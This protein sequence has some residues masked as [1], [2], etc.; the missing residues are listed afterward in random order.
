MDE[1]DIHGDKRKLVRYLERLNDPNI[2][3]ENQ[4][5]IRKFY[6]SC[7]LQGMSKGRIVR[8]LGILLITAKAMNKD[9]QKATRDDIKAFI[10]HIQ[11]KDYSPFTKHQYKVIIR[12]FY[13]WLKGN[14]EEYPQEVKWLKCRVKRSEHKLPGEGE[15]L[16]EQDVDKL[17]KTAE[18]SRDK[19]LISTL[20]ESG[21]RIGEI[22][23]LTIGKVVF[24]DYGTVISVKGKTG[25]RKIRLVSST[26]YL[27]N[28]IQDHPFK[29]NKDAQLW[30]TIGQRNY[31]KAMRYCTIRNRLYKLVKKSGIQ[32]RCNPH[33]FRHSRATYL[34]NHLTEFQMNQYFGW[35][36][37]SDM[38]ST[39]VHLS[40]REVDGAILELNG[41]KTE[42]SKQKSAL[43][44]IKCP[45]CDTFNNHDSKFCSK[46]GGVTDL[47]IAMELEDQRTKEK[48]IRKGSDDMMN[49]LMN[50]PEVQKFLMDKL[51]EM[52]VSN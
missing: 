24:D 46:C 33:M 4:K 15:L 21:C 49:Q 13:K 16:T 42:K 5:Y 3:K 40:G 19:A 36:Q 37:G 11:E 28:W 1:L 43:K 32:K 39:Y 51:S 10:M 7:I 38:P 18:T 6:E 50:N 9:F 14:D 48:E 23:T 29:G 41:L 31:H 12:R 45:R 52:Q 44:P 34:A 20:F 30:V 17:I 35:I 47:R 8:Y 2:C 22:A 27:A 26:S 25:S